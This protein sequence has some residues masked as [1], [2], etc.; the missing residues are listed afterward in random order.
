MKLATSG[1]LIR[2][3]G[4]VCEMVGIAGVWTISSRGVESLPVKLGENADLYLKGLVVFGFALWL[5][6]RMMISIG[7]SREARSERK[8]EVRGLDNLRL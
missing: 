5:T 6:G 1:Q 3:L 2:I 4:L 7:R 8:D